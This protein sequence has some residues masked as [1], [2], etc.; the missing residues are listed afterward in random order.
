MENK[1][2]ALGKGLEQLFSNEVIDFDNFEKK[3]HDFIL[4][5]Y[6]ECKTCGGR[7]RGSS[8]SKDHC[9]YRCSTR[10]EKGAL[11]CDAKAV[12]SDL[13]EE[14]VI[15]KIRNYIFTDEMIEFYTENILNKQSN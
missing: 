4:T 12:R 11:A 3:I 6:L 14:L 10:T 2:K 13:L 8:H 7:M 5:G 9:Y 1:R 15:E